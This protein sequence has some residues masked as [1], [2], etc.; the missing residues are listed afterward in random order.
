MAV[1]YT[2]NKIES[3]TDTVTGNVTHWYFF[4]VGTEGDYSDSMGLKFSG[5]FPEETKTENGVTT[6]VF[7]AIVLPDKPVSE[8]TSSEVETLADAVSERMGWELSIREKIEEQKR[9]PVTTTF[10]L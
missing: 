6:V 4:L 8:Y 9:A 10:E 5:G 7:P 1:T 2:W 3:T